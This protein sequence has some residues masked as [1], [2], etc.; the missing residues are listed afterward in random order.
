[1]SMKL[2]NASSTQEGITFKNRWQRKNLGSG[3]T[4][5]GTITGLSFNGLTVGKTYRYSGVASIAMTASRDAVSLNIRDGATTLRSAEPIK[6][7]ATPGNEI[8]NISWSWNVIF[9]AAST[10]CDLNVT[11]NAASTSFD[12]NSYATLEELN[13]FEAQTSAFT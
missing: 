10:T 9:T 1:M 12:T 13:N 4:S 6:E 2:P 3:F 7:K 5:T 11:S 8:E